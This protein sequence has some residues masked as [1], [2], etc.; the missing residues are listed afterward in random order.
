MK[1]FIFLNIEDPEKLEKLYRSNKVLFKKEFN[2]IY[3]E[4][5]KFPAA[6]FWNERLNFEQ[7]EIS[8]GAKNELSFIVVLSLLAGIIAKIPEILTINT[9]FFYARNIGFIVFPFLVH[10]KNL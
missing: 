9:E 7:Q 2:A 10:S 1:E 5:E 8:W 3:S 4:I 6:G